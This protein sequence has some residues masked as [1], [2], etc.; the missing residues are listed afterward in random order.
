MFVS[1]QQTVQYLWPKDMK[2]YRFSQKLTRAASAAFL[3]AL[4]AAASPLARANHPVLLEGNNAANGA[5]GTTAVTPIASGDYD[6]D[7]L[8]GT[9][10]DTDNATDRIFGTI[11]AA[12]ASANAGAN[13]NGR[14]TIVSSGRF[15][16]L[17]AITAANGNVTIEAAP[18]VEANL[19]AVISGDG[20][21]NTTRQAA[22][23]IVIEAPANRV[24]TLRNLVIRNFAIGIEIKGASRVHI[25]NCR[26]ENNR[27]HGIKV[28]GDAAVSI[29]GTQ[30]N[31]SGYRAGSLGD[32]TIDPPTDIANPGNG[33]TFEDDSTG[34]VADTVVTGSL[35]TGIVANNKRVTQKSVLLFDNTKDKGK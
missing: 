30:V 12:L 13:Q 14:V 5:P 26:I 23:G 19:D 20:A 27:D 3:I 22:S 17:V 18:G 33:I 2:I 24:V 21:G 31:G 1:D 11:G 9:A 29:T 16:E 7:G 4:V 25:D 34:L 15:G 6:G 10:E 35:G 28:S 32:T 8:V